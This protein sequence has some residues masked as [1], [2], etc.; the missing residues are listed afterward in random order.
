MIFPKKKK[1]TQIPACTFIS[2]PYPDLTK[3]DKKKNLP[4]VV[5]SISVSQFLRAPLGYQCRFEWYN[6]GKGM[7][8]GGYELYLL[9]ISVL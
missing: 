3:N 8:D 6:S 1:K 4:A 7:D 5:L 2:Y 9:L